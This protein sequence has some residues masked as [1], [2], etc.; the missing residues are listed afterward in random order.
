MDTLQRDTPPQ[1]L[2][3]ETLVGPSTF[4]QYCFAPN[5]PDMP[6]TK[7]QYES[8]YTNQ[9]LEAFDVGLLRF[10]KSRQI[11]RDDNPA[12]CPVFNSSMGPL[13]NG[14]LMKYELP[15]PRAW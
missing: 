14:N 5:C 7:D 13:T 2:G 12:G 9:Q 11:E 6:F 3:Y 4:T 1:R 8:W 10:L 15:G